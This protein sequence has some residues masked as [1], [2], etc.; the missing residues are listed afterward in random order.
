MIIDL[1]NLELHTNQQTN[2]CYVT[3][4]G[5][6]LIGSY[7]IFYSEYESFYE[8]SIC[9]VGQSTVT[10]NTIGKRKRRGT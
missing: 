3:L 2:E 5:K 7:K 10:I 9:P 1:G 6:K 4:D 8:V